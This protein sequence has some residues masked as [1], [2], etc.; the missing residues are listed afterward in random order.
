MIGVQVSPLPSF[1]LVNTKR[2]EIYCLGVNFTLN[3]KKLGMSTW[4]IRKRVSKLFNQT[5]EVHIR[6]KKMAWFGDD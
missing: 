4:D 5:R 3:P 6:E 2:I 1:T